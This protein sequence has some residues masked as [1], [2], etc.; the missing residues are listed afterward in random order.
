MSSVENTEVVDKATTAIA[1]TK[2]TSLVQRF[3]NALFSNGDGN[4]NLKIQKTN[5]KFLKSHQERQ[6]IKRNPEAVCR[7][8]F[9]LLLHY[10]WGGG[11]DSVSGFKCKYL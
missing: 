6:V 10:L 11:G 7:M 5:F 2:K 8:V 9:A 4:R 1:A 3:V